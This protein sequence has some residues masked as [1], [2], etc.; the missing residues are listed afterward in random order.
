MC[1][2]FIV[3]ATV[4]AGMEETITV[5]EPV[6]Q[7]TSTVHFK[8]YAMGFHDTASDVSLSPVTITFDGVTYQALML[9]HYH[10]ERVT[11]GDYKV[12]FTSADQYRNSGY[13]DEANSLGYAL[14]NLETNWDKSRD[15]AYV[16]VMFWDTL[17]DYQP[18]QN[19]HLDRNLMVWNTFDAEGNDI[20]TDMKSYQTPYQNF[21]LNAVSNDS[22]SMDG[23]YEKYTVLSFSDGDF[24][25]KLIIREPVSTFYGWEVG[26]GDEPEEEQQCKSQDDID[27]AFIDG[28]DC[29]I[30]QAPTK[31]IEKIVYVDKPV[32]TIV[33]IDKIVEVEKI[34]YIEKIVY[35]DKKDK[36]NK[37]DKHPYWKKGSKDKG[38]DGKNHKKKHVHNVNDPECSWYKKNLKAS[39]GK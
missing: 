8:S 10:S 34:V 6:D 22:F 37:K 17:Y 27:Q 13:V 18:D 2:S 30:A 7:V 32:E 38:V 35:V 21:L 26:S 28:V 1:L 16:Q 12:V 29:G 24:M 25:G 11:A 14:Y 15:F 31:E 36:K 4:T 9:E 39:K 20:T 5:N 19:M 23:I 3:V 33:Y